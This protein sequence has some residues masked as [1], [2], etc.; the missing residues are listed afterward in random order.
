[1]KKTRPISY[2]LFFFCSLFLSYSCIDNHKHTTEL[3]DIQ[4]AFDDSLSQALDHL[5]R[6][7]PHELTKKEH[8]LYCLVLTEG[9]FKVD[10]IPSSDSIINIAIK[11]YK[12]TNDSFRLSQS[13]YYKGKIYQQKKFLIQAVECYDKA[14]KHVG[15]NNIVVQFLL[16]QDMGK[17]YHFKMMREEEKE[18]KENAL[19]CAKLL[20]DS[21]LIGK[22]L[23]DLSRYYN[24]TDSLSISKEYLNQALFI[25]PAS[26]FSELALIQ[27]E[28]SKIH[29]STHLPDSALHFINQ[30]ISME[31]D[32]MILYDYYNLKADAFY[33]L[34]HN[35][36]AKYYFMRSLQS[37]SLRTK[38]TTYYDLFKLEE[39]YGNKNMAL[40]YLKAH[41]QYRDSL[42]ED[43]KEAFVDRLQNIEAYKREKRNARMISKEL[44]QN[45]ILFYRVVIGAF[46]IIFFFIILFYKT[47]KKKRKLEQEVKE[48][49]EKNMLALIKQKEIENKLLKEQEER[50]KEEIR[51]LN[52]TVN[53]YKR[54]NAIT[55]P[56]LL[57][58][59]NKQG[60]MHLKEE[61][62]EII[63]KNTD[64]CFNQF[65]T[66]IK[67]QF[68][69]LTDEEVRLCCLIKMEISISLL[70]EI[71]HI[72]KTSISRKKVRLKEK[73]GIEDMTIDDYI[74]NF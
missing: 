38:I 18:A 61:E 64:A 4:N 51:L 14:R 49:E 28:L 26:C 12:A 57:K 40:S 8:A 32:S 2:A 69:Q 23:I 72:A 71:Y 34:A 62:W 39:K 1:M 15:Q 10:S 27:A 68:P 25:M 9:L 66:R 35:D 7:N 48:E 3:L 20:N 63:I 17:I 41:V 13:L 74:R 30:A 73:M 22:S 55:V 54:L 21:L 58:S 56:I 43:R 31:K 6:I 46:I 37:H 19:R 16:N 45:K 67:T 50:E 59:Q 11:Y 5:Y 29:L 70:S 42:D 24:I 44:S 36:S 33:K 52:L 60:A 53:Y 47:Q 65:T